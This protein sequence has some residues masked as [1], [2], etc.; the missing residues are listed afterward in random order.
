MEICQKNLQFIADEVISRNQF[1]LRSF[2]LGS[3][4]CKHGIYRSNI[5][6]YS[7]FSQELY[8][9]GWLCYFNTLK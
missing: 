8:D 7:S 4:D 5:C 2:N 9:L 1:N 3:T 6:E